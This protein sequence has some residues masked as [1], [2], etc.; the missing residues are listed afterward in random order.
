MEK[1]TVI[2]AAAGAGK[3][4]GLG[5][6]K[7]F[8]VLDGLPVIVHNLS[9]I[10]EVKNV[11]KVIIVVG[12]GEIEEAKVILLRY[13][14]QYFPRL[15]WRLAAGGSERQDSVEGGLALV[16]ASDYIAVHDGARPFAGPEIFARVFS[17]AREKGAA[18]A[19]IPLKDTVKEVD[20][21]ERVRATPDRNSLRGIQTPQIFRS[22]L[23]VEAYRNLRRTG[24][25]VT[26]DAAAVELLGAEVGVAAGSYSNIKLTTPEDLVLA[27]AI[28]HKGGRE[29]LRNNNEPELRI[30][31]GFD[32]HKLLAGRKLIICGIE[33]PCELGLEGHSDA[34]VAVHALMD[35]LLGAL[36]LGDIGR[37]F[38]DTDMA[39]KDADS[40]ILLSK[41]MTIVTE[42]GWRVGNADIT[43]M[44]QKPRLAPYRERMMARLSEALGV[45]Q[46]Q[47]NVKATTTEGLGFV[48]RS[49]G[50]A[51]QAVVTIVR[52]T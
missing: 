33:I 43:I 5:L 18:V 24:K 49:E 26:D 2:V 36:G 10:N 27:L 41:V 22:S 20:E 14:K 15:K 35:A 39:Y 30:G 28:L 51:A 32:V 50:M 46:G 52:A 34:D 44:A 6:N 47:L 4:M 17:L 25:A 42:K 8:I 23:L 29:T 13:E 12:P 11:E 1:M 37:H 3:R 38:P 19:G 45:G 31:S 40:M 21:S 48:G 16:G 7:A 9:R